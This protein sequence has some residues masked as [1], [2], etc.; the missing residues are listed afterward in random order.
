MTKLTKLTN[1]LKDSVIYQSPQNDWYINLNLNELEYILQWDGSDILEY[2][3]NHDLYNIYSYRYEQYEKLH[4]LNEKCEDALFIGYV[5]RNKNQKLFLCYT[6]EVSEERR[7]SGL[8]WNYTEKITYVFVQDWQG[9]IVEPRNIEE[10]KEEN[11]K[12]W[13][14]KNVKKINIVVDNPGCNIINVYFNLASLYYGENDKEKF[15]Y[16]LREEWWKFSFHPGE[17]KMYHDF[18]ENCVEILQE[19]VG[20]WN[21][22]QLQH[23]GSIA[24]P[25]NSKGKAISKKIF[26]KISE[27]DTTPK[28]A[29]I[30]DVSQSKNQKQIR[31]PK[32]VGS[33]HNFKFQLREHLKKYFPSIYF[34]RM[35]FD[36]NS[37]VKTLNY[38]R[39]KT[40]ITDIFMF[41]VE[42]EG[43]E[44]H[45][46]NL[47]K[48]FFGVP[49][50]ASR[51][52]FY[53][54]VIKYDYIPDALW[55]AF[56]KIWYEE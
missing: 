47:G 24:L 26:D 12:D 37:G 25:Y 32:F 52:Y 11:M 35:N 53:D 9:E 8:P 45:V 33:W 5:N 2:T 13:N 20:K 28:E 7:L 19:E 1:S 29:Y 10:K 44:I 27:V 54:G 43:E 15:T 6:E 4:F 30:K 34:A 39:N 16:P 55:I 56:E 42:N 22:I 21:A 48:F 40:E 41:I 14:M 46:D 17:G 38:V 23:L 49:G 50:W 31:L 51:A 3:T 18:F 36:E